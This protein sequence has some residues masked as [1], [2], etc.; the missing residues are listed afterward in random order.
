[1]KRLF[2]GLILISLLTSGNVTAQ[3]LTEWIETRNPGDTN[4]IALGYPVPIPVN[5]PIPFDGFRT[6][7]GLHMRHQDL[8]A[9]T[10]YVHP[11]QIG[12]TFSGRTIWA[13]RLGDNDRLTID[14]L[15]EP[16]TLTNGGIHAREWQTPE[17]VTG[18]LELFALHPDDHHFYDYLRDNVNMIVIP[19]LN[20]DGFL[21]TQRTP[22]LNYMQADPDYPD[23]S[24]RDGRMR[25]KNMRQADE[26]LF[27]E[28]DL[29]NGVD[30]NRNNDPYWSTNPERSS[31]DLRSIVHHGSAAQSESENRALDAAAAL[32][33]VNRLRIY[34]D[35]HSFSQ[36]HFWTATDNDRLA[37]Q[38][39]EVLKAFTDHHITFPQA[40]WYAYADRFG[41]GKNQG[42][43]TTDE[44]FT[45]IYQ[46]PSWTLEVEPSGGQSFHEP[47]PGQGADYGGVS[48]NGHDGFILPDSQIRRVREELAQSFAAVYYRQAG[49]PNIQSLRMT[50]VETGAVVYQAEWD[51][52]DEQTRE[53]FVEQLQPLQLSRSYDFWLSFNKPMRWREDGEVV[54]FPGQLDSG[55]DLDASVLIGTAPMTTTLEQA[56]WLNEP[57]GAP[58]GYVN[59]Q[60]DALKITFRFPDDSH[61]RDLIAGGA[62]GTLRLRTADMTGMRTD[63]NPA[64]IANWEEGHWTA[65]ENS[66]GADSDFGGFDT[67]LSFQM[68]DQAVDNPY[69]LDA[70]NSSSWFDLTHDG[71]GFLLEML[72]NNIA[73]MFWYTFDKQGKQDWY[74]GTGTV[75]G[76]N[77]EFAELYQASGGKFGPDFDPDKIT[78]KIVGSASFTWSGCNEGNMSYRIGTDHGRM[79]LARLTNLWG[80]SCPDFWPLA[81]PPPPIP[82]IARLSGSWYDPAHDGEGYNIEVLDDGR[83]L[84]FWFTYDLEGKRRWLFGVG[85]E[86]DEKIVVDNLM[87]TSGGIFGPDFDP[88]TVARTTWGTLVFDLDCGGGTATYNSDVEGFGSGVLN[89]VKLSNID[90]QVSCPV[91]QP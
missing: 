52:V 41:V 69:L 24:P 90:H 88:D 33:P 14:G 39:E 50:D 10:D 62:E 75:R 49:P 38:T 18:I 48:E 65:Y 74:L 89:I 25:R 87:T 34:T 77:I 81:S 22:S 63:T 12:T 8:A 76:N 42:I 61:N 91:N 26:D 60:D 58:I 51:I 47:L 20:I 54:A 16:A 40:K 44:Y 45:A 5:T 4:I 68:T 27:T 1:M 3:V 29:L 53:L 17:V 9:S 84:V 21:Q 30:L 85:E 64:T 59:Y 31:A 80:L 6:Y 82:D 66:S 67:S 2:S 72:P 71:E 23:S 79:Q 7:A 86:R 43:G 46:V 57:G 19:S 83:V 56:A 78:R 37:R 55:L 28:P 32:G 15:P 11:E 36:V 73:L 70:S 35:V 13:Y